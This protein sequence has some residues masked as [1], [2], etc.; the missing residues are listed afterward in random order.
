MSRITSSNVDSS[1]HRSG[2]PFQVSRPALLVSAAGASG[3]ERFLQRV[4]YFPPLVVVWVI[5]HSLGVRG[6][7]VA[8]VL[9]VG[10]KQVELGDEVD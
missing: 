2:I 9:Q 6:P 10:H 1:N 5:A 4:G 3:Y 7:V 8:S